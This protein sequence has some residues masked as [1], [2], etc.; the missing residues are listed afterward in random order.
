MHLMLKPLNAAL[1]LVFTLSLLFQCSERAYCSHFI[2]YILHKTTLAMALV[3]SHLPAN[4]INQV[5]AL[6]LAHKCWQTHS[7]CEA[8]VKNKLKKQI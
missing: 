4:S 3:T 1:I 7:E 5:A 8:A 2:R 6:T